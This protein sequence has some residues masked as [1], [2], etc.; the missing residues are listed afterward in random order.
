MHTIFS[1]IYV[2]VA[3][4]DFMHAIFDGFKLFEIIR[5]LQVAVH[6]NCDYSSGPAAGNFEISD[7]LTF[8]STPCSQGLLQDLS[9]NPGQSLLILAS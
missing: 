1:N 6:V 8:S 3:L 5:V 2:T 4:L 9:N 7:R